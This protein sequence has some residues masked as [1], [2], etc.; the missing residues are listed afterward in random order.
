[1]SC[2][3]CYSADAAMATSQQSWSC[4]ACIPQQCHASCSV[5]GSIDVAWLTATCLASSGG[6]F[7]SATKFAV[8]ALTEG[9]R[10]EARAAKVPL[11]VSGI[12]PGTVETEFFTVR[13]F[14][15]AEAAKAV[16]SSMKCLEPADIASAILW[17][18]SAP[19]HMEVNDIVIRPSEQMI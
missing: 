18:L 6:T 19:P 15:D 2:V 4:K 14:G 1:M 10:Q 5:T 13:A 11:R 9:L 17:C 7:F 16:T 8:K 3:S 12:S